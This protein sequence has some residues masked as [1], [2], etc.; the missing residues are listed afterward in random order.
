MVCSFVTCMIDPV[1][2]L[3]THASTLFV[4]CNVLEYG[5]E[6]YDVALILSVEELYEAPGKNTPL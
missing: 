1:P 4:V 2:I 5:N 3:A 6:E